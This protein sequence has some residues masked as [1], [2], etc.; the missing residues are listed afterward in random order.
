MP[1]NAVAL[2]YQDE[3][4][5]APA[6]L[7]PPSPSVLGEAVTRCGSHWGR[8]EVDFLW[9]CPPLPPPGGWPPPEPPPFSFLCNTT[10][11]LP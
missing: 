4:L 6:P 7:N 8:G 1:P 9:G 3:L 2:T 5:L 10:R 11:G